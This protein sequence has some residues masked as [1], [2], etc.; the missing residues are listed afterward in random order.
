MVPKKQKISRRDFGAVYK[1]SRLLSFPLASFRVLSDPKQKEIH[2]A[3]VLPGKWQKQKALRNKT[4]RRALVI[5]RQVL[6]QLPPNL[7]VICFL[8]KEIAGLSFSE[9]KDTV[10][11]YLKATNDRN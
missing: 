5:L 6:S 8:K 3:V 1:K 11:N 10:Q 9:L 4:K 7:S 2:F